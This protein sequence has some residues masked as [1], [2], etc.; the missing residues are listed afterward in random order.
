MNVYFSTFIPGLGE[1]VEATLKK[2]IKGVSVDFLLDGLVVY[3]TAF[4]AEEIKKLPFLN[5]SFILLKSF[6][7]LGQEPMEEMVNRTLAQEKMLREIPLNLTGQP[8]FRVMF[9]R[10]NQPVS[11]NRGLLKQLEEKIIKNKHFLVD[12][13][14][15]EFEFLYLFRAEGCGFFGLRLT[16]HPDYKK[17]LQPGELRPEL[18]YLLCVISEPN[19]D[20]IFLDPFAGYGA[21]PFQRLNYFKFQKIF[22]GD[23]DPKI[24][25]DLKR[26]FESL[27]KN[28]SVGCWDALSPKDFPANSLDKIVT[29]PPW[30]IYSGRDLNLVDFYSKMLKE[31]CRILKNEGMAVILVAKKEL[32][33][34]CLANFFKQLK[35][36]KKYDILVSGKKAAVYKIKKGEKN[37][38]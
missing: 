30:G 14:N 19:S 34:T 4:A 29:D 20:D 18:A 38:T 11:I 26:K 31:F 16:R 15:P 32:F 13:T 24:V 17:I 1:V 36:I 9:S 23:I 35:L 25:Y 12:R 7:H 3:R 6:D 33:E 28:V 5:N 10:E 8:T 27:G 37:A 22:V 21:I 2:M